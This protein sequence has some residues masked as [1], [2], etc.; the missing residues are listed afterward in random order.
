MHAGA[1]RDRSLRIR[2][3]N[4]CAQAGPIPGP[5]P[6]ARMRA[7]VHTPT[8]R[9]NPSN[10]DARAHSLLHTHTRARDAVGCVYGTWRAVHRPPCALSWCVQ[11]CLG[12]VDCE[13]PATERPVTAYPSRAP[14]DGKTYVLYTDT[15]RHSPRRCNS[16]PTDRSTWRTA[17]NRPLSSA[18]DARRRTALESLRLDAAHAHPLLAR[19]QGASARRGR[20]L[21]CR[22]GAV[23]HQLRC[24]AR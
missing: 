1:G 14:T 17:N 16:M 10:N 5:H 3:R 4:R 6:H 9:T 22:C 19:M 8:Q 13:A 11:A 18:H 24:C 21:R 23:R 7:R 2:R 20:R 12:P 15:P